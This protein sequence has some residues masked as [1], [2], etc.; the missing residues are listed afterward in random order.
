[1]L[2]P[3]KINPCL[4]DVETESVESSSDNTNVEIYCLSSSEILDA[5]A[6]EVDSPA[7]THRVDLDVFVVAALA[8]AQRDAGP[9]APAVVVDPLGRR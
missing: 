6:L 7:L 1:M 5:A 4:V 9:L 8:V 2:L 3:N